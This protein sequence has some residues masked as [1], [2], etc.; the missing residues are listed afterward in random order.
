MNEQE[1]HFLEVEMRPL[2]I[3]FQNRLVKKIG[4]HQ[5]ELKQ[6]IYESLDRLTARIQASTFHGE[7]R[8]AYLQLSLLQI[9]FLQDTY[10]ICV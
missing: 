7:Y 5:Q 6:Q 10:E 4:K 1:K 3:P 9:S 2:L 8:I